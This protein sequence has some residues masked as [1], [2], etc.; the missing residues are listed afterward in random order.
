MLTR[1]RT[2]PRRGRFFCLPGFAGSVALSMPLG[3]MSGRPFQALQPG[4]LRPLLD[5]HL[6]KCGDLAKQ[7]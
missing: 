4:N 7:A 1:G 6:L 5:N 3:L 2:L